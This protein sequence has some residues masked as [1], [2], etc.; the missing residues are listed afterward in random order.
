M[1]YVSGAM[2]SLLFLL[3]ACCSLLACT[4]SASTSGQQHLTNTATRDH[5][6]L[7]GMYADDYFPKHLVDQCKAVLVDLC[8]RIEAKQPKDLSALYALTHAAT[9]RLNHLQA[10]F[11]A[12]GSELET[13]ARE[14]IGAD[15]AFIAEAYG[16]EA[17]VEELIAPRE[18]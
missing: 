4:G 6:F 2:R 9:E 1:R 3:F 15:F 5:A 14:A 7:A 8:H 10:E 12:N 18:W 11:E 17:D 16:F 13:G